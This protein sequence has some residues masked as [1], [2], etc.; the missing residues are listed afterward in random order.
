MIIHL[1]HIIEIL[2]PYLLLINELVLRVEYTMHT[3][4]LLEELQSVVAETGNGVVVYG[5]QEY[6][7]VANE[8]IDGWHGRNLLLI[9]GDVI[10]PALEGEVGLV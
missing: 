8:G 6:Y 4:L 10:D 7:Q 3:V 1:K 9:D 2:R 5:L